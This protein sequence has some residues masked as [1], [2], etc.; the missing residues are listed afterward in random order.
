MRPDKLTNFLQ[1]YKFEIR[2][3]EQGKIISVGDGIVWISGL[4]SAS[5]D[6]IL[7]IE[8]GSVAMVFHLT[9]E[10]VGAVLLEQTV[11]LTSGMTVFHSGRILSTPVSEKLLGRVIDPLGKLLDSGPNLEYENLRKLDVLSPTIIERD[12]VTRPLY[13]GNKIIDNLLPIGKGQRQL[14]IGDNGLGKS[15]IALDII[16]NQKDKNIICIYVLIGQ[17]NTTI[18]NTVQTLQDNN[19]LDYTVVVAAEATSLPGL[20]YLAPYAGCAIA[21]FWMYAGHDTLVIFDDLTAHADCYREMSLLLKKPVGREAYPADIFY[22]HARL[23]ERATSLS[24]KMGGGS[25]TAFPILETKQGEI[26]AYIPT[27]LISITDG[28]FYLDTK[29]FAGGFLPA[30]DVTRSV[31]R[32]G[33]KA[34][35]IQIKKEASRM[36]L[37]YLQFLELEVF[38]HFAAHLD[39]EMKQKIQ[40]GKILRE[41]LKQQRFSLLTIE[42]QLGWIIAYNEKLFAEI[43]LNKISEC[44][45]ELLKYISANEMTLLTARNDW[46]KNLTT[47]FNN[48]KANVKT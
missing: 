22:L 4:P 40:Q 24:A 25:M 21:E 19:A 26:A 44:L 20:Q 42:Q 28:Q 41:L 13:T 47:W 5:I 39:P 48:W 37:D 12:F 33:G 43:N 16:L 30:I 23:L 14:I 46:V 8:D 32:I 34:Q 35:D 36:K 2:I 10:M 29:L 6:E 3:S 38:T 7:T 45:F 1:E 18:V 9:E 27:N 11:K 15:S 17:K 31:S